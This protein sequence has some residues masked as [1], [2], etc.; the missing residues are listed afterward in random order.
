M[1][2]FI[3]NKKSYPGSKTLQGVQ[4]EYE[5]MELCSQ[6]LFPIAGTVMEDVFQ[7]AKLSCSSS[8]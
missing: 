1:R 5:E 8:L 3:H 2:M 4:L 7:M 6:Y